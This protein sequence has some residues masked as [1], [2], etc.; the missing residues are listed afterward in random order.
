M[1]NNI[2]TTTRLS[3]K[4]NDIADFLNEKELNLT[5]EDAMNKYNGDYQE[6]INASMRGR[7]SVDILFKIP[8]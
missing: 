1:R 3:M 6:I 8:K 7:G 2:R 4:D 5:W